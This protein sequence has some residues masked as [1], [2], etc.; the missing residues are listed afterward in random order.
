MVPIA[1]CVVDISISDVYQIYRPYMKGNSQWVVDVNV[2]SIIV[3]FLS[4][5]VGEYFMTL[6]WK[7]FLKQECIIIKEEINTLVCIKI[8]NSC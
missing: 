4:G 2:T 7:N 3:M 1:V 8:K 5:K 6:Q